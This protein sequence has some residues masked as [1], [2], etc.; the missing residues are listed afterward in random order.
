MRQIKSESWTWRENPKEYNA[1]VKT[2]QAKQERLYWNSQ[3]HDSRH[4]IRHWICKQ[5]SDNRTKETTLIPKQSHI[6]TCLGSR[7]E[8]TLYSERRIRFQPQSPQRNRLS[9]DP[10][11]KNSE[12]SFQQEAPRKLRNRVRNKSW[13]WREDGARTARRGH[14]GEWI[15]GGGHRNWRPASIVTA[16]N[17]HGVWN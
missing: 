8:E 10:E 7:K 9:I 1:C 17:P 12:L 4:G 3:G 5:N 2:K 15:G 16:T 14:R 13:S 6:I 11:L